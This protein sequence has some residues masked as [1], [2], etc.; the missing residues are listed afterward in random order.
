[1][2][3][4]TTVAEFLTVHSL[5]TYAAAFEEEG[6]DNLAQLQ[7]MG[8]ADLEQLI[9]D[10]KMKSGHAARLRTALLRLEPAAAPAANTGQSLGLPPSPRAQVQQPL[11]LNAPGKWDFFIS[12]TQ[13]S[14]K[15]QSLAKDIHLG[16]SE[17]GLSGWLDTRMAVCDTKAMKEGVK[18]SPIIIAI[19]SGGEVKA[20]HYWE[21]G[22]HWHSQFP[23][24]D[25]PLSQFLC[26]VTSSAQSLRC[27]HRRAHVGD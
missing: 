7:A 16:L 20:N 11:A 10:T 22:A 23:W 5:Q 26:R 2:A 1:M 18:G 14:G 12:Y 3:P 6:W 24:L 19:I 9:A 15:A 4:P 25:P 27:L 17:L 21:R 8:A 13:R